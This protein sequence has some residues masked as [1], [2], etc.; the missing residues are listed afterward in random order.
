[1]GMANREDS[2]QALL[3]RCDSD[4]ERIAKEYADSL[5]KQEIRSDLQVDI[6]NLCENLRSILDYI[7]HDIR[8]THCVSADPKARFYFPI[9]PTRPDFDAQM[10][11]SY[12]GLEAKASDLWNFLERAQPYHDDSR[13]LGVFNRIN[14]ENKHGNLVAQTRTDTE[15]VRVSFSSGNVTWNPR[16]VKF[17]SG[18]SIGGVPVDPRTQLPVPHPSQ[19]VERI[20]WV[21]FR[22]QGENVSALGLL[23]QAR[24]GIKEIA[25]EIRQWL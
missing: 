23:R 24:D 21:D 10:K 19:N 8:E 16:S 6:K 1:M 22:F 11:K 12:P 14:N 2:I 3:T 9:L 17:G 20:V 13:W 7:A 5:H 18:V 4:L 15:Q 25:T